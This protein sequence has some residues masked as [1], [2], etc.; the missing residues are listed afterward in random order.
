GTAPIP[1]GT[2]IPWTRASPDLG[3]PPLRALLRAR[4][5]FR[6][7]APARPVPRAAGRLPPSV[8]L[9]DADGRLRGGLRAPAA[10]PRR[11]PGAPVLGLRTGDCPRGV[12]AGAHRAGRAPRAA[13]PGGQRN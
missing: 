5:G 6:S 11:K 3:P 7:S 1:T 2:R 13:P 4:P 8:V 12:V 10:R 9:L